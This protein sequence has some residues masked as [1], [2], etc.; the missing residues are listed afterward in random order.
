M[1]SIAMQRR[2]QCLPTVLWIEKLNRMPVRVLCVTLRRDFLGRSCTIRSLCR[3]KCACSIS[4][5]A[6]KSRVRVRMTK[7]C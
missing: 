4:L 7:A 1:L 3:S 2:E 5:I 6:W